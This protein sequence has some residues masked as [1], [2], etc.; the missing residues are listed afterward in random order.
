[1]STPDLY[2]LKQILRAAASSG[3]VV[4]GNA[5]PIWG[6]ELWWNSNPPGRGVPLARQA[7]YLE[8]A[9]YIL[10]KQAVQVAIWFEVRDAPVSA[11]QQ[12]GEPSSAAAVD[13]QEERRQSDGFQQPGGEHHPGRQT[14]GLRAGERPRIGSYP[15]HLQP[16]VEQGH[17][18]DEEGQGENEESSQ[19]GQIIAARKEGAFNLR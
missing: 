14:G 11:G 10:W 3:R 9:M 1:M 4:P 16:E 6:T 12:A 2:K 7:R 8:Q 17:G 13:Q 15:Q 19:G 5:K 18:E